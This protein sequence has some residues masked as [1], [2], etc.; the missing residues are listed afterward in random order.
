MPSFLDLSPGLVFWTIINFSIF[1]FIIAKYGWKPMMDGLA[2]REAAIND[3]IKSAEDASAEAKEVL[4]EAKSRIANAQQE[5]AE[6]TLTLTQ[7][8][9]ELT[10]QSANNQIETAQAGVQMAN[11][12]YQNALENK[13]ISQGSYSEQRKN[14]KIEIENAENGYL[15]AKKA[16]NNAKDDLGELKDDLYDIRDEIDDIEDEIDQNPAL[17]ETLFTLESAEKEL[18]NALKLLEE[19]HNKKLDNILAEEEAANE[20]ADRTHQYES[21]TIDREKSDITITDP[22]DVSEVTNVI[23][24]TINTT[25]NAP[26][27]VHEDYIREDII[28][29]TTI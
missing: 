29:T 7:Q 22:G 13:K 2:A 28:P 11:L 18:K 14:A 26:H 10:N 17:I 6:E 24:Q 19:I 16:L 3:S 1:A 25:I 5:A 8:T 21:D 23:N 15:S 4:K 9:K 12:S 20:S 27:S